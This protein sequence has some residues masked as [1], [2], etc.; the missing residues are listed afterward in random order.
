MPFDKKS[1]KRTG[2][3]SNREPAKKDESSIKEMTE[4]IYK[5]VLDY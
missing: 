4:I 2:K 3:K 5:K 1:V